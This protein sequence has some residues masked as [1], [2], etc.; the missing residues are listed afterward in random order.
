MAFKTTKKQIR[1]S[2]EYLVVPLQKS[3]ISPNT[4]TLASFSIS[5]IA[6]LVFFFFNRPLGF[7]I[8]IF[9]VLMDSLD[10]ALARKTKRVTKFGAYL[11]SVVDK[12]VES[13]IFFC[14]AFYNWPL[15]FLAGVSSILVSY[16]RHRA[17]EFK[18]KVTGGIFE[19]AERIGFVLILGLILELSQF[20][21]LIPYI[22]FLS[23]LLSSITI[24]QRVNTAKNL[25]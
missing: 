22:L 1:S 18:I 19:R 4:I 10:G 23:F 17:D 16:S 3:G 6:T 12:I 8:F 21:S 25:L 20:Q 24:L 7:S 15:A 5:V 14:F 11:D 13:L 9:S 2:L